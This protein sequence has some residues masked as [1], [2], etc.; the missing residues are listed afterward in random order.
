MSRHDFLGK[1]TRPIVLVVAFVFIITFLYT[2]FYQTLPTS[3]HDVT[4]GAT[5]DASSM[6]YIDATVDE[7]ER[8]RPPA[9]ASDFSEKG[10]RISQ[11]ADIVTRLQNQGIASHTR[12]DI[13]IR[14]EFP[15]W[16]Q[17]S[18]V[19][20]GNQE[21]GMVICVG[22]K[23]IQMAGHLILSL[24]NVLNYKQPIQIAYAGDSDL[25]PEEQS[26]L[27]NLSTN[28]ELLNLL[29]HFNESVVSLKDGKYAMKPFAVIASRFRRTILVD[30]DVIFLKNPEG[31]FEEHA[32]TSEVGALFYHDRAYKS[33]GRSRKPW[34]QSILGARSQSPALRNS[35]FWNEDLWQEMESG[36]VAIDKGHPRM[37][38]VL[39]FSAW[40][41]MK[42][43]REK[44]TYPNVL[45]DKETYWLAAELSNTP[46]YFQPTYAGLVGVLESGS[47][48]TI[49][50]SHIL[51]MDHT[52]GAP[53]WFNGGI[54]L[55]K[56]L[57]GKKFG[58]F[59]H[60]V[61]GGATMADQPAWRYNGNEYWCAEGKPAMSL[62]D[63]MFQN[64]LDQILQE[65][66]K[67]ETT[68]AA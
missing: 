63:K 52:G 23:N 49:C 62:E 2:N 11:L 27:L 4:T 14:D 13:L 36:V 30:A 35:L 6:H 40:M 15:W 37:L 22:S 16:T 67:V 64:V 54:L 8:I 51:H 31:I 59:T 17:P 46:Y 1:R 47:K 44:E 58:V 60:F 20:P 61:T 5:H 39:L 7:L 42:Y 38:M 18:A 19:L 53:F 12:F 66:K 48:S 55:N 56:A 24:R 9:N 25:S 33:A 68:L 26:A 41:N 34:I 21:D 3:I 43:I 32:N 28:L 10:N 29:D 45:G 50:S 65:A 57:D